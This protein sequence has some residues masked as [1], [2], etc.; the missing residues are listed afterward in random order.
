MLL[1]KAYG[2]V[3]I[4]I[5]KKSQSRRVGQSLLVAKNT[6]PAQSKLCYNTVNS[7]KCYLYYNGF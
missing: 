3:F 4:G 2:I 1:D 6:D 5:K 7:R